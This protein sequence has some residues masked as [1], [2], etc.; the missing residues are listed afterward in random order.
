MEAKGEEMTID[1]AKEIYCEIIST[2][3]TL[4]KDYNIYCSIPPFI[5]LDG[6]IYQHYQC[7]PEKDLYHWG[8]RGGQQMNEVAQGKVKFY[9]NES[10]KK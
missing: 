5:E 6:M 3:R 7:L 9:F 1:K 4:E 8:A 10:D 2:I